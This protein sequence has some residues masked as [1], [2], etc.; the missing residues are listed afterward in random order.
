MPLGRAVTIASADPS[1]RDEPILFYSEMILMFAPMS[2][3]WTS[4]ILF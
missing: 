3:K 2:A 1:L 4:S